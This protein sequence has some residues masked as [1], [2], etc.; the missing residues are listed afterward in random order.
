MCIDAVG[1]SGRRD[2][3]HDSVI[4]SSEPQSMMPDNVISACQ[5]S[6]AKGTVADHPPL[7][8]FCHDPT[9]CRLVTSHIWVVVFNIVVAILLP[10]GL[11]CTANDLRTINMPTPHDVWELYFHWEGFEGGWWWGARWQ[12]VS[13]SG[14]ENPIHEISSVE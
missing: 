7:A 9:I 8:L 13:I 3:S 1:L 11:F 6:S 5:T 2:E 12:L 14:V 4:F 10:G